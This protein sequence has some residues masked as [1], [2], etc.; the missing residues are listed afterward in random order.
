MYRIS[1]MTSFE[2]KPA[3]ADV[4][5]RR[6][7]RAGSFHDRE[8]FCPFIGGRVQVFVIMMRTLGRAVGGEGV[9][10]GQWKCQW[11]VV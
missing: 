10:G 4:S 8:D 7:R 6:G 9:A 5:T 3:R 11:G 1:Y 2:P